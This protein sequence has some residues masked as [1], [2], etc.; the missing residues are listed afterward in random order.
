MNAQYGDTNKSVPQTT[1]VRP[2]Q[3]HQGQSEPKKDWSQM[4]KD[5]QDKEVECVVGI[6]YNT[7]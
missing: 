1:D 2:S 5:E 4:T 3:Q 6:L 7:D